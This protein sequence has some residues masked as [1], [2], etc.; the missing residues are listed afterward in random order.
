M[1]QS[2]PQALERE[3]ALKLADLLLAERK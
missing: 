2:L 1:A 3:R